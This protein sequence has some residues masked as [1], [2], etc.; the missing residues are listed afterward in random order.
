MNKVKYKLIVDKMDFSSR[1]CQITDWPVHRIDCQKTLVIGKSVD[2]GVQQLAYNDK[3]QPTGST[4][5]I[6][7]KC[8]HKKH[9][10]PVSDSGK[11]IM[12]VISKTL[13]VPLPQL[14]LIAQGKIMDEGNVCEVIFKKK[15]KNFMVCM[16]IFSNISKYFFS[17]KFV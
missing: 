10:I 14:K 3:C 17:V 2:E 1:R 11:A 5:L 7:I 8:N 4:A 15:I 6:C 13:R 16:P 12:K 9:K